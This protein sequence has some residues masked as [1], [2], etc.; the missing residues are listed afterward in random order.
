ME[1]AIEI[2][3]AEIEIVG[4]KLTSLG[5]KDQNFGAP[6]KLWIYFSTDHNKAYN[7]KKC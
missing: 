3:N 1:N 4:K 5:E 6:Y 2:F 7:I